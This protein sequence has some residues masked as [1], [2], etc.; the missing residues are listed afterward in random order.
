MS[1]K[2]VCRSILA[3]CLVGALQVTAFGAPAPRG[4]MPNVPVSYSIPARILPTPD[5]GAPIKASGSAVLITMDQV[6]AVCVDF[7]AK[8]A[9]GTMFW[10]LLVPASPWAEPYDLGW[11]TMTKG[12]GLVVVNGP[13]AWAGLTLVVMDMDYNV[14]A[15]SA[16]LP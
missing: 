1:A 15:Q 7:R 12:K 2:H 14:V 8:V 16:V 3:V 6:T 4:W 13:A 9:D 5:F 10:A 11:I